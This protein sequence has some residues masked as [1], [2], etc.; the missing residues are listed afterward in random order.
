MTRVEG[1]FED[2]DEPEEL[3]ELEAT[4]DDVA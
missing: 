3:A 2:D 1:A 4:L